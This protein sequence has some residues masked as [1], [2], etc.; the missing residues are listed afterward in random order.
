M[1]LTTRNPFWLV[2]NGFLYS[3]PS[4]QQDVETD[5]AVMGGGITGALVAYYLLRSGWN[6]TVLDRRNIGMGS[7]SASTALLQYEIDLPLYELIGKVGYEVAVASYRACFRSIDELEK[8]VDHEKFRVDFEKRPSLQ[9]ASYKKHVEKLEKEAVAREKAGI[10][11]E[12]WSREKLKEKFGIEAPAALFSLQGAQVD[13]F[14]LTHAIFQKKEKQ[15]K[16]FDKTEVV[17]IRTNRSGVTLFT[18]TRKKVS[19]RYL[20]VATGYEAQQY[21]PRRVVKLLSTYAIVSEPVD[22]EDLW[23]QKALIWETKE[24]YL[25]L[26]TTPDSRILVGG[27]DE[28]TIRP[29]R[30]KAHLSKKADQLAQDF[31]RLMPSLPFRTD[32]AWAGTFGYTDDALPYV[33]S[34]PEMPRTFFALGFGGNGITFSVLAAEILSTLLHGEKHPLQKAFRFER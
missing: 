17:E 14:R 29:R 24:P 8:M 31:H 7:T 20:I 33:G 22:E 5:V 12:L 11:V 23:L 25:Y 27:R 34:L 3:Y 2:K 19:A 18:D 21:L 28:E 16:V 32:F 13:P 10:P 30:R 15:L 6:V 9:Y 4:L 26:R 1:E